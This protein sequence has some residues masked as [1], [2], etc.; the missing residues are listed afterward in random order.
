MTTA[1]TLD[2]NPAYTLCGRKEKRGNGC[3]TQYEAF[4]HNETGEIFIEVTVFR[5]GKLD[6]EVMDFS[7][8][9][10]LNAQQA[11]QLWAM[12]TA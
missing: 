7:Q 11:N 4:Q 1:K 6:M 5:F 3:L 12:Y 10:A 2:R 8:S 9:E